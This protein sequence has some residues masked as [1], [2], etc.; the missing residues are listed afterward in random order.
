MNDK[1][2][3][4]NKHEPGSR[5]LKSSLRLWWFVQIRGYEVVRVR[6]VPRGTAFGNVRYNRQWLVRRGSNGAV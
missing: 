5:W 6:Q 1:L 3:F 4:T 2:D